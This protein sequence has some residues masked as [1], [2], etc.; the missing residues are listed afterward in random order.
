M[1]VTILVTYATRFGSTE[2]VAEAV[3][4]MLRDSGYTVDCRTM[5]EVQSLDEY[6]SVVLGSANWLPPA[7]DFVRERQEA[8]AEVPVALFTVHIQNTGDDA[9][10]RQK[11]LAYLDEVRPAEKGLALA[12]LCGKR[13]I[14]RP[15]R[16]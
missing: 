3:A 14:A 6:D 12:R 2:E 7:I 16:N 4:Q 1:T 8:L 10:S 13:R 11:R 15:Q 9:M 5:A